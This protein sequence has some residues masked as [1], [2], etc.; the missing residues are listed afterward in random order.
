MDER[1]TLEEQIKQGLIYTIRLLRMT[2]R[3]EA[4][5]KTKLREKGYS[6][7]VIDRI[8]ESLKQKKYLND[9]ELA[10]HSVYWSTHGNVF[11]KR[12]IRLD[13]RRKGIAD[14][15]ISIAFEQCGERDEKALAIELARQRQGRLKTLDQLKRKKRLY[16]FLVR[17]GFD[18]QI[19]RDV[20]DELEK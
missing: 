13:L 4:N 8:I 18:Y 19:C 10:K 11:G 20:M 2:K 5:I 17:R 9:I 3:S 14:T 7:E 6:Q 1:L 15:A 16:D 12:R